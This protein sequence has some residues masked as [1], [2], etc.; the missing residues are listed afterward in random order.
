LRQRC[1]L[2][3]KLLYLLLLLTVSAPVRVRIYVEHFVNAAFV[4]CWFVSCT[5]TGQVVQNCVNVGSTT[6][7]SVAVCRVRPAS[8]ANITTLST[9]SLR[10]LWPLYG[11]GQATVFCPVVSSFF[12]LSFRYLF[13][14]PNLNRRRLDVYHTSS[15]GVALVRIW[16]AGLKRAAR[17]SLKNTGCK[18]SPKIRHLGTLDN[19]GQLATKAC[20]NNRKKNL[21]NSNISPY[22]LTLW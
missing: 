20:I 3:V 14:S 16:D 8:R 11:I 15:H 10:S 18:I 1:S 9:V 4:A 21:L 12:Y 17:G 6:Q 2:F 7:S 22:V 13:S 19:F 5:T